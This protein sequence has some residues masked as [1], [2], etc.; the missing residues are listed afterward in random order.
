MQD[1]NKNN[2]NATD[3]VE[4][5]G[6]EGK[7]NNQSKIDENVIADKRIGS[8]A[9]TAL[10]SVSDSGIGIAPEDQELIFSYFQQ[11]DASIVRQF[12]GTG[13]GL[14][15]CR[16]L[17]NLLGGKIWVKSTPKV[18][19]TFFFTLKLE[20]CNKNIRDELKDEITDSASDIKGLKILMV[21]DNA[22]NQELFKWNYCLQNHQ[23]C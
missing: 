7:R 17:V 19:T 23:G 12:G 10:F 9:I 4:N 6:N 14:T 13:L 8:N 20:L 1:E 3:K 11:A 21:E 18:G 16:Q 22:I 2:T 15:I 5:K